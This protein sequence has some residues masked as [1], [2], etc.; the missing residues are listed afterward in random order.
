MQTEKKKFYKAK[1][2][3]WLWLILFPP[4]GIILL[5]GFHKEMKKSSKIILTA[6]FM[7]WFIILRAATNSN[8][9][10]APTIESAPPAS[11]TASESSTQESKPSLSTPRPM[12][13]EI[14][15]QDAE[16]ACNSFFT[17]IV[18]NAYD[19]IP[20]GEGMENGLEI[21]S[22]Y[23]VETQSGL[24]TITYTLMDEPNTGT[25]ISITFN[26]EGDRVS[27]SE[28]LVSGEETEISNK[29]KESV[30]IWLLLDVNYK[31]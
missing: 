12:P 6:V 31:G 8:S 21:E 2:F 26:L 19:E 9:P 13:R 1:W 15:I 10:D 27:V 24:V 28:V 25:P 29:T 22:D 17:E 23:N 30:L 16:D 20:W 5:W 14:S 4:V 18:I 11:S 3:L 7:I